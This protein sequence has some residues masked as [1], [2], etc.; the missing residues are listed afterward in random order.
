MLAPWRRVLR[1]VFV[2]ERRWNPGVEGGGVRRIVGE[3]IQGE[4]ELEEG[5]E[6]GQDVRERM[7]YLNPTYPEIEKGFVR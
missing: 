2:Q 6:N 3:G 1:G 7:L 5:G 4:E